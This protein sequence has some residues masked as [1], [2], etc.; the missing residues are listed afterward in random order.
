[1]TT[2]RFA[3]TGPET[4]VDFRG[5]RAGPAPSSTA[6]PL[7]PGAWRDGRI[8]LTG[9]AADNTLTVAG[10]MAYR[11]DGEGLHRHVDPHDQQP[12]LYAMSFLDAGPW[13]FAGF[14]QPDLKAAYALDV[15]APAGLDGAGQRTQPGRR[16]RPL[17]DHAGRSAASLPGH[18]GRRT[19]R[20]GDPSSTAPPGSGCTPGPACARELE[21]AAD[22]LL[23]VTG[24]ALDYYADLFDIAVPVR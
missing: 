20:L 24:Q 5:P 2:I 8:A 22:D 15:R 12:Y 14:D 9:L 10:R 17:D 6:L 13:W 18:P 19:V 21:E 11:S 3:S 7:D 1:M 4:F 23:T 16:P